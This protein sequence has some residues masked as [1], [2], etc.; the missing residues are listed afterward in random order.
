MFSY[1]IRITNRTAH[2]IIL[3]RRRWVIVD[4]DGEREEVRGDGVSGQNPRIDPGETFDYRS[5]CPLKTDWGTM[6]GEYVFLRAD[7]STFTAKIGRFF[8]VSDAEMPEEVL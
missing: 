5:F 3:K 4:S 8:L 6:E 1:R 2:A 7:G